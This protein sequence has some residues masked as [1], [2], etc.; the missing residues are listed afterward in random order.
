MG[1]DT[2]DRVPALQAADV[3]AWSAR[4]RQVDGTLAG[5]FAP[6]QDALTLAGCGKMGV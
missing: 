5:E 6:L 1:F 3:L 4:R 2:D